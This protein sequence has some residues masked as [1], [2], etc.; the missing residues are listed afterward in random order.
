M[1]T[2]RP[3]FEGLSLTEF[4]VA[5]MTRPVPPARERRPDLPLLAEAVIRHALAKHPNERFPSAGALARAWRQA[6]GLDSEP[7]ALDTAP[8]TTHHHPPPAA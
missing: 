2:G 1:V 6:I 3:P 5:H 7:L 4:L 8:Q